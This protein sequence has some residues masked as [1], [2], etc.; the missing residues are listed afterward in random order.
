MRRNYASLLINSPFILLL[1]LASTTGIV[2]HLYN[3]TARAMV[4]VIA[5][6]NLSAKSNVLVVSY[7]AGCGCEAHYIAW[8]NKAIERKLDV[9]II[10]NDPQANLPEFR[11]IFISKP[12][13]VRTNVGPILFDRFSPNKTTTISLVQHGR[14]TKQA[15]GAQAFESVT[16]S[17]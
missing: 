16:S 3:A 4:P 5:D 11:S 14:I 1:L 8:M 9:L 2:V 15:T 7:R 13:S 17:L 10:S 12:V 6:Y